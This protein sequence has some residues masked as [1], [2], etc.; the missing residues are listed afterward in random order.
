MMRLMLKKSRKTMRRRRRR[1]RE[2]L[3]L[4]KEEQTAV[5][6]GADIL[7]SAIEAVV[8]GLRTETWYLHVG[9]GVSVT[10]SSAPAPTNKAD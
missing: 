8:C 4:Q 7:V 2:A 9:D 5:H 3:K 6:Q 10:M 1:K